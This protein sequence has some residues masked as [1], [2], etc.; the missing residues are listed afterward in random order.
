MDRNALGAYNP[1]AQDRLG[2]YLFFAS[3]ALSKSA[4]LKAEL[5]SAAWTFQGGAAPGTAPA[6]VGIAEAGMGSVATVISKGI[7]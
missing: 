5:G 7:M 1:T 3:V 4:L 6:S 2:R